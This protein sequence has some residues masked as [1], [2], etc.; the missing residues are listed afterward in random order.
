MNDRKVIIKRRAKKHDEGA[1]GGA[2]KVA[3]AD[4]MTA[5]MTFFMLMWL[6]SMISPSKKAAVAEYFR[7]VSIFKQEN[8]SFMQKS[9]SIF[10]K[11]GANAPKITLQLPQRSQK[12][13]SSGAVQMEQMLKHLVEQK[14]GDLKDQ[15]KVDIIHGG[16]RI[17]IM[18]KKGR[19]MF[20]SGSANPTPMAERILDVLGQFLKNA[21]N[22]I[23][24]EGHTDALPYVN[25]KYTNWDLS[26]QRALAT[27]G[28]LMTDGL[29]SD[30]ISRITG[31]GDTVPLVK[32]DPLDPRNRRISVIVLFKH[33]GGI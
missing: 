10:N 26:V 2:W 21:P 32:D 23:A 28:L 31:Y 18:D 12:N 6:I 24:V 16:V 14:L 25:G 1:H 33:A 8:Q 27:R 11:S 15:I 22:K 30:R 29:Q 3:Y 7:N 5:M 13:S 17:Q 20:D 19:P 9:S 4:F